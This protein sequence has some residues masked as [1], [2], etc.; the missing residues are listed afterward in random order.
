MMASSRR[1]GEVAK[2]LCKVRAG[3]EC[4]WCGAGGVR[5]VQRVGRLVVAGTETFER[6]VRGAAVL[7]S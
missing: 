4:E 7:S 5:G 2:A 3:C 1:I 6:T